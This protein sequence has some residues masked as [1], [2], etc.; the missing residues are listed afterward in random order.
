MLLCTCI[1]LRYRSINMEETDKPMAQKREF[2][3]E[4]LAF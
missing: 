4:C 2:G 3:P 1:T